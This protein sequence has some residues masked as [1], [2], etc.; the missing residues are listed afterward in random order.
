VR[1]DSVLF[2]G[3]R[4]YQRLARVLEASAAIH[5]PATPLTIHRIVGAD[6][7]I[8]ELGH[9]RQRV[10]L[11]HNARKTRHHHAI[12]QSA[13]DGELIGLLDCDTM[14]TG[15]LSE[16][17]RYD[18][19]LAITERP[20]GSKFK[21]NSGVVFVRA[22]LATRIF[23]DAWLEWTLKMLGNSSLH[24]RW[25]RVYGGINQSALGYLLEVLRLPIRVEVLPCAIWNSTKETWAEF[26]EETKVV[27]LLG[28]L[29]S[30]ALRGKTLGSSPVAQLAKLWCGYEKSAA[31]AVA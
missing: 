17:A 21:Y 30:A 2:G 1:I 26:S 31:G 19:D 18:F 13:A 6:A 5:S 15:D 12:V 22:S 29:R 16:M 7:D 9:H 14:V 10:N 23:Y 4:N 27:H 28:E 20:A 3:D 25:K 11:T 24:A 8:V